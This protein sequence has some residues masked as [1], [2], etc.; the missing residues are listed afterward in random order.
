MRSGPKLT[1]GLP[2]RCSPENA[3]ISAEQL[4]HPGGSQFQKASANILWRFYDFLEGRGLVAPSSEDL[5]APAPEGAVIVAEWISAAENRF[6]AEAS[7]WGRD[8]FGY[9]GR[10]GLPVSKSTWETISAFN[11]ID[12]ETNAKKRGALL[13][14]QEHMVWRGYVV[15]LRMLTSR[16]EL[17]PDPVVEQLIDEIGAPPNKRTAFRQYADFLART[18]RSL[19][20]TSPED[21]GAYLADVREGPAAPDCSSRQGWQASIYNLRRPGSGN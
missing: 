5:L 17:T 19:K 9:L 15:D 11:K 8:Y 2:P 16:P 1:F 12:D 14:L 13:S 4:L 10:L 7:D 18:K 3:S 20:D 21:I 6:D